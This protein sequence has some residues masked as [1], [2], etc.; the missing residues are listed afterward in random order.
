MYKSINYKGKCALL[1]PCGDIE[2]RLNY[3]CD[4]CE[5]AFIIRQNKR[6][7]TIADDQLFRWS[8]ALKMTP[9][10]DGLSWYKR[11]VILKPD[12]MRRLNIPVNL[13]NQIFF[14][15]SGSGV[16]ACNPA[17]MIDGFLVIDRQ[18]RHILSRHDVY[19]VPNASAMQR[20]KD[21][22]GIDLTIFERKV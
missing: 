13:I 6:V 10:G 4:Y 19:G 17:G 5:T 21:L 20:Y 2:C 15:D 16:F 11:P 14:C 3:H 9:K 7:E 8:D 18:E 12:T 22:F 1:H